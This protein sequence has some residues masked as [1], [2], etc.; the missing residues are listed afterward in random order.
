LFC[1]KSGDWFSDCYFNHISYCGSTE[2]SLCGKHN[3]AKN[4]EQDKEQ[5]QTQ[6]PSRG[7]V[8]EG[9]TPLRSGKHNGPTVC[10]VLKQ[11]C[12]AFLTHH[13]AH[14]L[15]WDLES[16][17]KKK[18]EKERDSSILWRRSCRSALWHCNC[19]AV[20]FLCVRVIIHTA[21]LIYPSHEHTHL[22]HE[23][24]V[25]AKPSCSQQTKHQ[26]EEQTV[27]HVL[28]LADVTLP[29]NLHRFGWH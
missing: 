4:N 25:L 14:Y 8:Q 22:A 24:A 13:T 29:L 26:K 3:E 1:I 9:F 20:P 21:S 6:L 2:S 10:W 18:R 27:S 17:H 16:V 23:L 5:R 7:S 15:V 19:T 12:K 11:A 28:R